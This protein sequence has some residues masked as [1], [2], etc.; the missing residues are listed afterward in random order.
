MT[1]TEPPKSDTTPDQRTAQLQSRH[2]HIVA[3][4]Q[5]IA[6]ENAQIIQILKVSANR[7]ASCFLA[8]MNAAVQSGGRL[9]DMGQVSL[10]GLE[11]GRALF[12]RTGFAYGCSLV[13][14][15]VF[16]IAGMK[17]IWAACRVFLFMLLFSYMLA[18]AVTRSMY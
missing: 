1:G 2:E 14:G 8:A 6:S 12:P 13:G 10:P 18:K 17:A 15:L 5:Q 3:R 9:P 11:T 4:F 16:F 7:I